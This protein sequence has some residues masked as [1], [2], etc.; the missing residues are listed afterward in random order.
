MFEWRVLNE[1]TNQLEGW[2][3]STR[4]VNL[5]GGAL[6]HVSTRQVFPDGSVTRVETMVYCAGEFFAPISAGL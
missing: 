6:V 5:S 3:R 2:T 4:V 1:E